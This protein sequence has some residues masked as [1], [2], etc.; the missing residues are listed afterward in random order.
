[1]R[2]VDTVIGP[3]MER[4]ISDLENDVRQLKCKHPRVEF[5]S[6]WAS[7]VKRCADCGKILGYYTSVDDFFRAKLEYH[8]SEVD[9][10]KKRLEKAAAEQ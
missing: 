2:R 6:G 8:Q 7:D 9:A 5:E 1:M 3:D 10:L 4:R